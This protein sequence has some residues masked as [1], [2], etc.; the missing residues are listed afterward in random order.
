[1]KPFLVILPFHRGDWQL[2]FDLLDWIQELGGAEEYPL[3][4]LSSSNT[5]NVEL[6][7]MTERARHI[8]G[9]VYSVRCTAP[10]QAWPMG[11]NLMFREA[12]RLVRTRYPL[13]FLWLEPDCVPLK[14]GWLDRISDEYRACKKPFLGHLQ[15]QTA[16]PALPADYMPGCSVYPPNAENLLCNHWAPVEQAWDVTTALATVPLAMRSQSL[17][18]FWGR[19]NLPPTFKMERTA[20]DPENVLTPTQ[21]PPHA[22]LFHRCKDGSLVRCLGRKRIRT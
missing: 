1:M 14:P 6:L 13:P 22:V 15:H 20:D 19:K 4:L 8:F 11:P 21:I 7:R 12:C 5:L 9:Q 18:E 17:F 16:N 10:D 2:A 3:L